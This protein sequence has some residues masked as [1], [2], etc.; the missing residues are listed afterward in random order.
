MA[1]VSTMS[2]TFRQNFLDSEVGLVLKTKE[3]PASLG[4]AEGTRT[5]VPAGT[6]FPSDDAQAV[7]IVFQDVDVTDGPAAGS[8]M[9]G[10]RV[11][12]QR[13]SIASAARTAL[14]GR[15]IV[16]ADA[17]E[18][19]RGFRATYLQDDGTGTPPV[20]PNEYPEGGIVKVSTE[21][22][23][24]KS[25]NTQTGWALT[26]GGAAVSEFNI[27]EDTDLYPVWTSAT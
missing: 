27:T 17:P 4:V 9:V 2:G 15:G 12:T 21:S 6:A 13:L 11:L 10:G 25:G 20:D 14:G 19:R 5:V 18:V 3:I 26:K 1:Y 23:L 16:F 8:V 24:T 7:G 22:P